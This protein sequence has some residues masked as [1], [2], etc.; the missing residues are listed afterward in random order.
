MHI[1]IILL[2]TLKNHTFYYCA[3]TCKNNNFLE[4]STYKLALFALRVFGTNIFVHEADV[5][6]VQNGVIVANINK[7][8]C[9]TFQGVKIIALN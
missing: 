5:R 8:S 7:Q 1:T 9:K 2:Y 6:V 4:N 3:D